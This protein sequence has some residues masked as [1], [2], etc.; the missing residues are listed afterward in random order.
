MR[1]HQR[2]AGNGLLSSFH[3]SRDTQQAIFD[4]FTERHKCKYGMEQGM[5]LMAQGQT[6]PRAKWVSLKQIGRG[7]QLLEKSSQT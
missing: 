5:L 1:K 2:A 4:G 6:I 7:M 3:L